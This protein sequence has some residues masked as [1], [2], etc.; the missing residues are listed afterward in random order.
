MHPQRALRER[1][2]RLEQLRK[3]ADKVL[4]DLSCEFM[5]MAMDVSGEWDD[6][7]DGTDRYLSA[8]EAYEWWLEDQ[9]AAL[10]DGADGTG[11]RADG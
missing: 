5:V 10:G 7:R 1:C 3:Q 6:L 8:S 11:E 9:D 4:G 2:E